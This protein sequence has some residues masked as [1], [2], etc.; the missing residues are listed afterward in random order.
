MSST[1]VDVTLGDRSY[2]III[3]AGILDT[4]GSALHEQGL[5]QSNAFFITNPQVGELYAADLH[6]SL[7]SA[8]FKRVVR[9]DIPVTEE[10]KNW[11]EFSKC[12][13][14]LARSFPDAGATPLIF[15]LGGGVV[16]DLGGFA[17]GVFRR[18]VPFVQVPTTLLSAVDSSV[19]G[20][21]GVN[22][23]EVKNLMGVFN[24]P[25]LVL[26]D[27]A[28]LRTLDQREVRSG[29]AEVIKYGAVCSAPLFEQLERGDLEK[30]L[31]LDAVALT[32]VV[33][34]CCRLKAHVVE[35]DEFDQK[36]IRNVLNFGHTVGHALEMAAQYEL[37]HGDAISVGMVA[38]TRLAVA[39]GACNPAFLDR[40]QILLGRAGLPLSYP[41]EAGVFDRIVRSMQ[42]D[43]KFR[44]GK[45]LFV[46]PTGVGTWEQRRDVPW[47]VVHDA[48]RSVLVPLL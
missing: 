47:K 48:I 27:L 23:G 8:G 14:A 36:G 13:E 46:L 12:C 17:A 45:N 35:Q 19:G 21:V 9:Y 6:A 42:M 25:R 5:G 2:P 39:L 34:Q 4:L 16:G 18:G 30:V 37:T 3:G 22:F 15:A 29:T 43:K 40:L 44:D 20:K 10:G 41:D 33:A 7:E 11:E 26:C 32:D 24:Q 31:K 38:A 1:R 28:F